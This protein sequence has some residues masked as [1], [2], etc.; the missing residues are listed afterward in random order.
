MDTNTTNYTKNIISTGDV[1]ASNLVC[2]SNQFAFAFLVCFCHLCKRLSLTYLITSVFHILRLV[3]WPGYRLCF[4][5]MFKKLKI[6]EVVL[7]SSFKNSHSCPLIY[8]FQ[9]KLN[10]K[11][12]LCLLFAK[13]L[14]IKTLR[15]LLILVKSMHVFNFSYYF[16]SRM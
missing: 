7:Y 4:I 9:L 5:F 12:I 11:H 15:K 3:C 13:P 2:F 16:Y 6:T 10:S 8:H 14:Q 1:A